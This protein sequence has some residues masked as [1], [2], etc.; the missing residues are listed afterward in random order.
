MEEKKTRKTRSFSQEFKQEAVNL[1]SRIGASKAAKELDV[2]EAS[3][4]QW[5]KNLNGSTSINSTSGSKK[6]YE[7]LEKE[8]RR[9]AKEL[10]YLKEINKVLKK[11]TAIFSAD[12]MGGLK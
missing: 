10:G 1:A 11:S 2:H 5:K 9:L 6:S 3:I 8:N 4:R 12:H 7:E